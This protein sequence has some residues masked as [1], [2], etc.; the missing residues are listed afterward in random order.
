MARTAWLVVLSGALALTAT[1]AAGQASQ[2]YTR[3]VI[4]AQRPERGPSVDDGAA[5]SVPDQPRDQVAAGGPQFQLN[6][7]AIEGSSV[8]GLAELDALVADLI[9]KPIDF[10]GLRAVTDRIEQLYRADGYLAVR[11]VIPAQRIQGGTVRVVIVEG[12]VSELVLRGELGRAEAEVRRLLEPLVGA[13]P[14]NS[15]DAERALLLAR[16]VPGVSLLAALR[17]KPSDTPG[18]LVLLV[19]AALT[20]LDG[21]VSFSNFASEFA[22]PYIFTAGGGANSV[23]FSGDRLELVALTA[24]DKGEQLLGQLAYEVPLGVDGLRFRIQGSNVVSETGSILQPLDIDY[25]SQVLR[26]T[27]GYDVIRSRARTVTVAAGFEAIHQES[28]AA[29]RAIEIDEDLRVPFFSA[30]I[31]E[32]DFFGAR[33]DA[34]TELRF[35]I[36]AFGANEEGDPNLTGLG[37]TDPQF[38]SAAFDVDYRRALPAGFSLQSRVLGQ[39]STGDLP[40]YERFSL[41]N[42][43]I[44]RGYEPGALAGDHGVG[45]S[46]TLSYGFDIPELSWVTTPEAFGFFDIGRVWNDGEGDGLSSVGLGARWQMF[47]QVDAE[48]FVAVPVQSADIVDDDDVSGLFRVTTFF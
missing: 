31:I 16:D 47:D 24:L 25:R 35:G 14:L 48:V 20:P 10:A 9:G 46:L 38:V 29:V 32:N 21:F 34:G 41:G 3:E 23:V 43:T 26:A 37:D 6:G 18:E 22:G 4:E 1:G 5:L 13:K 36:D 45:L 30:R 28:N 2:I 40:T 7:L 33:L 39:V 44:G 19:E 11:A 15:A 17:P 12:S 42:Y 8:Y 27:I